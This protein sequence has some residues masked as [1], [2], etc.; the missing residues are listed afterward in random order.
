MSV[1]MFMFV[2]MCVCGYV[3]VCRSVCRSVRLC[4]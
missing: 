4:L 3:Y 1:G 2:G